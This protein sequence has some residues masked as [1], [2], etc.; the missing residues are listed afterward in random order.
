MARYAEAPGASA[1]RT[2]VTEPELNAFLRLVAADSLPVGMTD[3]SIRMLGDGQV[4]GRA[5]VDLDAVRRAAPKDDWT[6]VRQWLTGR[7]PVTVRGLLRAANGSARFE[8]SDADVA[9]IPVP[10]AL[11]QQIVTY[12]S[13]SPEFPSGVDL[14][15]PFPLPAR[16]REIRVNPREAV[17]LQH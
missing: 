5:T 4:E 6:D 3:P 9:G 8:L 15:A 14:D 17:V 10:K 2:P 7:V 1:Q 13:R 16:I 11:L 12:Y